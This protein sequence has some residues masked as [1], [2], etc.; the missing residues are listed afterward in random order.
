MKK[1]RKVN[2]QRTFQ[3]KTDLKHYT[4]STSAMQDLE[5]VAQEPADFAVY[6]KKKNNQQEI[7]NNKEK[8]RYSSKSEDSRKKNIITHSQ[9]KDPQEDPQ[10]IRRKDRS[11]PI[12]ILYQDSRDTTKLLKTNIKNIKDFYIKRVNN[13]K[14]INR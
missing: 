4:A 5:M 11:S 13:S 2:L 10:K 8:S 12:N 1:V 14:H 3:R 6:L 9:A 7:I